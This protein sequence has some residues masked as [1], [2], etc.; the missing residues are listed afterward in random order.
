MYACNTRPEPIIGTKVRRGHSGGVGTGTTRWAG[1]V[2]DRGEDLEAPEAPH[3]GVCA[4][5]A[6]FVE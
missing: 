1:Q 3:G 2:D 6:G 5:S 4:S